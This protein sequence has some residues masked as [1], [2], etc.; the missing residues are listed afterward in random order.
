MCHMVDVA[1]IYRSLSS[2]TPKCR[3][4]D[5]QIV[6]NGARLYASAM[7]RSIYCVYGVRSKILR[8]ATQ[9]GVVTGENWAQVTAY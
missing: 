4:H 7:Y 3:R 6:G 8:W 9:N 2:T 1:C 5:A